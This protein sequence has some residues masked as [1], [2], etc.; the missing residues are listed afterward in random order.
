MKIFLDDPN[1]GEL[2]K[3]YILECLDSNFISTYG[4]YTTRFEKKFADYLSAPGAAS[5]QS[6]TAGLHLALHELGLGPEDEVIV[7]VL[8]FVATVNPVRYLGAR[9]VFVDIDPLTWTIDPLQIEGA[10]TGRTK[11]IIVVHLYGNPCAMETILNLAGRHNLLVIEDA[12]ESLGSLYQH[13]Y[14]G[15]WGEFGVFSFNGNKLITT[16][17][18][19]M[20][21]GR[22]MTRLQHIQYLVNQ[23]RDP[24]SDYSH[25]EIGFNYRMTNLEASLGLAQMERLE[26][27]IRIKNR[28]R[29]QYAARFEPVEEIQIQEAL[30]EARPAWWLSSIRID[31]R[32][33]GISITEFQA[34]LRDRGVPSR[35]VFKPVGE[36][37]PYRGFC[38]EPFDRA[39]E[40]F[41][42]GLNLPSSTLNT[43]AAIDDAAQTVV[44][45]IASCLVKRR[46]SQSRKK[47][48]AKEFPN[49]VVPGSSVQEE[50]I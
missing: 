26:E 41:E 10:I 46:V 11:A 25:S 35:R 19:G 43:E 48:P 37:P 28:T 47:S 24:G 16:G 44:K 29:A 34:L 1:I 8:T 21:V 30:P 20:V 33:L 23:A 27:F 17:G 9:P 5:L 15:T 6:G 18:G 38:R 42:R 3:R 22:S 36:F 13:R 7:P 14:T 50:R 40:L 12:T 49:P 31:V 39:R 4:P 45:L 2:E 32:K